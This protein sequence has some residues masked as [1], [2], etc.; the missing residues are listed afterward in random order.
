[1][2]DPVSS[3]IV[4]LSPASLALRGAWE[5]VVSALFLVLLYHTIR[6]LRLIGRIHVNRAPTWPWSGGA[7]T[8][9]VSAILLPI[10]LFLMQRFLSQLV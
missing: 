9:F 5:S 6:Q 7:F 3:G 4:G 1:M 10:A 2:F 8:G